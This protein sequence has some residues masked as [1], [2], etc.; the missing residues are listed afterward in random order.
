MD[1]AHFQAAPFQGAFKI[2]ISPA[3][4]KVLS[5]NWEGAELRKETEA[6]VHPENHSQ[7]D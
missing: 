5:I 2:C 4:M 3:Q 7:L 6:R 1:A